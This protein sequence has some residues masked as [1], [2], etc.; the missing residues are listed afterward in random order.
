MDRSQHLVLACAVVLLALAGCAQFKPAPAPAPQAPSPAPAPAPAPPS[1]PAA[2]PAPDPAAAAAEASARQAEQSL[3]Q[4]LRAYDDGNYKLAEQKLGAALKSG[5]P[6]P[7]DRAS[8]HKTLAFLYCT[9]DRMKAC[10]QSFRA[11]RSADPRFA[12][13]KA[14]SGHPMWGPV[15]RRAL[16]LN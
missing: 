11:A 2:A 9:S 12:L 14:E 16:G 4:G 10:E 7:R 5:L 13:S 1:A 15:Y 8:A 3:Q 6:A